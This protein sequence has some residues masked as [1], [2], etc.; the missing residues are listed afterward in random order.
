MKNNLEI[1][2]DEKCYICKEAATTYCQYCLEE[3]E[4]PPR[5]VPS[6]YY[7]DE[8]HHSVVETGNC[9]YGSEQIWGFHENI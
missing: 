7:F 4:Y 5:F 6:V 9:C 8:H 1:P 3:Y 2:E